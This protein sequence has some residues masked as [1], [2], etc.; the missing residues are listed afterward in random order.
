MPSRPPVRIVVIG[1]VDLS[2]LWNDMYLKEIQLCMSRAYGPGSYDSAYEKQGRDYP[3][4]Y[5]RWTENRNMEEFLRLVS[6][7][8]VQIEPLITHRFPLAQGPQA[9]AT[10]LDPGSSSLAVLLEYQSEVMFTPGPKMSTHVPQFENE[11]R[12]S[13]LSVA[14]T[15]IAAATRDGE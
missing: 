9:Y 12:V 3:Y 13:V 6:R 11:A 5:V 1:A 7:G 2:F 10:I 14:A 15:V 8:D 4:S